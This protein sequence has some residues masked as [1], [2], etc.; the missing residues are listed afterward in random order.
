MQLYCLPI[1]LNL[2]ITWIE[3]GAQNAPTSFL[4]ISINW[5]L[6]IKIQEESELPLQISCA[7][8]AS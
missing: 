7:S 3:K 1:I 2:M 5:V 6:E 4:T 8:S